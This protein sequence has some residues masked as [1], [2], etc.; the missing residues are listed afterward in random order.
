[1]KRVVLDGGIEMPAADD[2]FMVVMCLDGECDI[3]TDGEATPVRRGET[4]L[5]PASAK[6]VSADGK[7]T[8]LTATA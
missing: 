5:V 4:L 6:A 3:I 7:A 1:M 8:L 2:S